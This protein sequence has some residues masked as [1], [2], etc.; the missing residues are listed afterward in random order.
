MADGPDTIASLQRQ[1][2]QLKRSNLAIRIVVGTLMSL[3]L[4]AASLFFTVFMVTIPRFGRLF[5]EMLAGEP[6]P[7]LTNLVLTVGHYWWIPVPLVL[8]VGLA[9]VVSLFLWRH[10]VP[11]IFAGLY[12]IALM[13]TMMVIAFA[14]ILPLIKLFDAL[15]GP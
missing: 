11:Y 8:L 6:L 12:V 10:Y 15:G 1:V 14:M 3:C 2:V 5:D 13:A 4:I 7:A 9:I